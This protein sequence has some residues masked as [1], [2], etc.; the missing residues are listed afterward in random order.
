M[1][2]RINKNPLKKRFKGA[3]ESKQ[4]DF[5]AQFGLNEFE[6]FYN[7]IKR[8]KESAKDAFENCDFPGVTANQS[9]KTSLY[10]V[11]VQGFGEEITKSFPHVSKD[12]E[13][14][15]G[16]EDNYRQFFEYRYE[17]DLALAFLHSVRRGNFQGR[18][19]TC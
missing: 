8:L 7:I 17:G 16:V 10:S 15:D 12:Q 19:D 4:K 2:Q 18:M 1:T 14:W 6:V 9:E 3:S 11:D 13:F 5:I